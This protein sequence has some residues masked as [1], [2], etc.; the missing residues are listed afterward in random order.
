MLNKNG[1]PTIEKYSITDKLTKTESVPLKF[2]TTYLKM[3][4]SSKP[5]QVIIT[6]VNNNVNFAIEMRNVNF[7]SKI[8]FSKEK[9]LLSSTS[10]LDSAEVAN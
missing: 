10:S 3:R 2:K 7:L 4:Q 5:D 8:I 1:N 9:Q 6:G